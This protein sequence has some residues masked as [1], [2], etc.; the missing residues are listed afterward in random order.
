[1]K[2]AVHFTQRY[3]INFSA[4][5]PIQTIQKLEKTGLKLFDIQYLDSFT[6]RLYI[7]QKPDKNII[8][9][10]HLYTQSY[11]LIPCNTIFLK[12][13]RLTHRPVLYVGLLLLVFF[14][15]FL[16][17][18]ILFVQVKG[19]DSV[20]TN[21]IVSSAKECGIA[22]G[23]PRREIRNEQV[24]NHLIAQIPQLEWVGI[25]TYGCVAEITVRERT[26][27]TE[28]PNSRTVGSIIASRDGIILNCTTLQGT[29]ICR[30]GQA[31]T[32]GQLL[33]SGYTDCGIYIQGTLAEAEVLAATNRENTFIVPNTAQKR[34]VANGKTRRYRLTIGNYLINFYNDSGI[35]PPTCVKIYREFS[36]TLPGGFKLPVSVI[37]EQILHYETQPDDIGLQWV[38]ESCHEYLKSQMIAGKIISEEIHAIRSR[39]ITGYT[40]KY[41]CTEIIGQTKYEET[42]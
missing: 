32:K 19:N 26:E 33:V 35:S 2:N 39:D 24:K 27:K 4:A 21:H 9:I 6:I 8:R 22:F 28:T 3:Q 25:N 38:G 30:P 15:L 31:V 10:L 12:A 17:S 42:I 11:Q 36:L 29:Q 34:R 18:R 16:P 5:D 37:Q 7:N 41:F 1:M 13:A 20:P 23:I 14:T 40:G